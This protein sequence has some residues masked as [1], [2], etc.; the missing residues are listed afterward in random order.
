MNKSFFAEVDT[1]HLPLPY[2]DEKFTVSSAHLIRLFEQCHYR[3]YGEIVLFGIRAAQTFS[4]KGEW[5]T[6]ITIAENKLDYEYLNCLLGLW[7]KKNHKIAIF[8]GST[9]PF[10][11]HLL[12]QQSNP[13]LRLSNQLFQGSYHY[14]VGAHEPDS[15]PKE[16]GAFRLNRHI[17]TPVWRNYGDNNIVLDVC[18]P[19]DHIHA[20]GTIDTEYRSAGC[21]VIAGFHDELLP[22][23][24]YQKFR[25][26][27]GQSALS[28]DLEIH[29]PYQYILMHSRHL[30]AI[31]K[32]YCLERLMQGSE[33][34]EVRQLQ[35][36]LIAEGYLAESIIDKGMMCGESIR[37]VYEKQKAN[38]LV[39]DGIH[40]IA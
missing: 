38:H 13:S 28:S 21:Q 6:E 15:R 23:G 11:E 10:I 36:Q 4:P 19:N 32:G 8:Q 27:A 31:Q 18:K 34:A 1:Q 26:L 30:R 24:E 5:L 35:E 40:R 3:T 14:F 37:A 25:I 20:A 12:K 33:G 16:E 7:D 9:V 22:V 29:L 2:S 39:I 17:P